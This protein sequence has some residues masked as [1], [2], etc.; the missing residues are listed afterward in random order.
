MKGA[1]RR[2]YV[3]VAAAQTGSAGMKS[4]TIGHYSLYNS[5]KGI[6]HLTVR[7]SPIGEA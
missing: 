5:K 3:S 2:I 7:E 4:R 6:L 1:G